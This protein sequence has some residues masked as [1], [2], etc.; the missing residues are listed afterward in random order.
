M[1]KCKFCNSDEDLHFKQP[2]K[3]GDR[4][5]RE[6]DGEKHE[7]KKDKVEELSP[8]SLLPRSTYKK[9]QAG[10]YDRT[11]QIHSRIGA[12]KFGCDAPKEP[13]TTF[14]L[15]GICRDGTEIFQFLSDER[16]TCKISGYMTCQEYCPVCRKHPN[17]IYI[18]N[19]KAGYFNKDGSV[20]K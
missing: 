20:S 4:P 3:K 2:Y 9:G 19:K 14:R 6:L 15:C 16:C 12:Y 10:G 17:V 5:V 1:F 11:Q 18:T 7:C 8:S 13:Y